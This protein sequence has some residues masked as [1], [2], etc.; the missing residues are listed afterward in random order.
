MFEG[1]AKIFDVLQRLANEVGISRIVFDQQF[2][3][4]ASFD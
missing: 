3:R 4:Q 1:K 2:G